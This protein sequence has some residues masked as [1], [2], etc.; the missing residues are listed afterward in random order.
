MS[1]LSQKEIDRIVKGIGT[2]TY[3]KEIADELKLIRISLEKIEKNT[4]EKEDRI[5]MVNSSF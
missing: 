1:E 3:L 2:L 4:E 5:E